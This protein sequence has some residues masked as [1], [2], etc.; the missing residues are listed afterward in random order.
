[1]KQTHQRLSI[2]R[3]KRW[4]SL[5]YGMFIHFGMSTYDGEELSKGTMP[6]SGF[7]PKELDIEQWIQT[8]REAGM[9]YA[10]LTAKHVAGFCLWPTEHTDYHVGNSP[11]SVDIVGE[12]VAA[13]HKYGLRPGLYYCS[14]DNHHTFGKKSL[15][16]RFWGKGVPWPARHYELSRDYEDFQ[17]DQ[18]TEL[19]TRYE[20]LEEI[21]IDIPSILSPGY[22]SRIYDHCW[23]IQ[24]D[25]LVIMNNGMPD[26]QELVFQDTWPTDVMTIERNLPLIHGWD[27]SQRTGGWN[28]VLHYADE[29]FYVPA[30][31]CDTLCGEWFYEE[32]DPVKPIPELA[33]MV[34]IAHARRAN[35]LLN[36]GPTKDGL[37]HPEH[38]EALLRMREQLAFIG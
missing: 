26:K 8:A 25:C 36:V 32:G 34:N 13:C 9:R 12:F 2:E 33:G 7:N 31:V 22:R 37:I 29:D 27:K 14:W 5:R 4:E 28:P 17:Q 11:V 38:R 6:A 3:L 16:D 20:D 35:M 18:L 19:L 23:S 21:W 15:T 1:M 24:P 30:E 10:V